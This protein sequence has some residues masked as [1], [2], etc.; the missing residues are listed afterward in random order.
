MSD[1][2][3][4]D[5]QVYKIGRLNAF[6]Q[7]HIMRRLA[8]VLP[9]LAGLVGE[10]GS[11]PLERLEPLTEAV[12]KMADSDVDYVIKGCLGAVERQQGPAWARVVTAPGKAGD[13]ASR[14]LLFDDLSMSA[15]LQLVYH[16]LTENLGSFFPT[17]APTASAAEAG[18]QTGN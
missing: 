18:Q 9:T 14:G 1:P 10:P 3:T 17:A 4:V 13:Q 15:M 16:V 11:D 7:L 12:S 8:P 5:G 6:E 2:K